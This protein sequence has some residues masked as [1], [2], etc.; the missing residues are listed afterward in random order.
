MAGDFVFCE[1]CGKPLQGGSLFCEFCGRLVK[2]ENTSNISAHIYPKTEPLPAPVYPETELPPAPP[3]PKTELPSGTLSG[4]IPASTVMAN[5]NLSPVPSFTSSEKYE[6]SHTLSHKPEKKPF[7][8]IAGL[9]AGCIVLVV[10]FSAVLIAGVIFVPPL[11]DVNPTAEP[12]NIIDYDLPS[13]PDTS[14]EETED[15]DYTS[16]YL[17]E[18]LLEPTAD[19]TYESPEDPL[20]IVEEN[21]DAINDKDFKRAY[22]FRSNDWRLK[23][24]YE[25]YYKLWKTNIV[26]S[27]KEA[28]ILYQSEEKA[29]IKIR[30]YSEDN[31][32]NTGKISRAYYNGSVYLIKEKGEWKISE[33]NVEKE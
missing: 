17:D 9:A 8:G 10:I 16:D 23:N 24:S 7:F 15:Y 21:Y 25:D 32:Y 1:F 4:E 27:L 20:S 13:E 30:L 6:T 22:G 18:P 19:I 31:D 29:K 28:E 3:Y 5:S 33:V 12:T 2:D 26:I 14:L 11:M